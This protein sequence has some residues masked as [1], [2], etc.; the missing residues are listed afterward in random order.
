MWLRRLHL[1]DRDGAYIVTSVRTTLLPQEDTDA[2]KRERRSGI[3]RGLSMGLVALLVAVMS[4]AIGCQKSEDASDYIPL[5]ASP[6]DETQRR[7][8]EELIRMQQKAVPAVTQALKSETPLIR[9]GALKVLAKVRRMDSVQLSGQMIDDPN[10]DVQ[11]Q[12]IISLNEL[13]QVW[14]EKSVELLAHALDAKDAVTVRTAAA[15]LA[16]MTYDPATA[17]LRK[18]FE[19]KQGIKAVYAAQQLYQMEPGDDTAQLLLEDIASPDK[20]VRD[21]EKEALVDVRDA[22]GAITVVGLEDK[23][24]GAL[25][26]YIDAHKDASAAQSMLNQ[27]R[28]ALI[29][30]LGKTL[31]TK[32]AA[33][34]LEALGTIADKE[35]VEKLREDVNDTRLESS[36][37]VSAASSLGIAG[38]SSRVQPAVRIT[39]ITE[40]SSVLDNADDNRVRIGASIALCR[41]RLQ[42][43]VKYLLDQLSG[44]EE[45]ISASNMTESRRQDLT[46][47][48]IRAQEALTQAG[49]YVVPFLMDKIKLEAKLRGMTPEMQKALL[50]LHGEAR[51][52]NIIIWAAAKTMGELKVQEAVPY[53]GGYVTEQ[54][55]NPE[56]TID[57][58]GGLLGAT[59]ANPQGLAPV[60]LALSN[61][62]KPP[63]AEVAADQER[64]EVFAYPDYVRLTA[65]N[66]L[67]GIGGEE[68]R[69]F[70]QK[71]EQEETAFLSRLEA[72]KKAS[73]YYKRAP[74][75]EGLIHKHEDV[76][77]YVRLAQKP[78]GGK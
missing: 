60:D 65:A 49:D 53:L 24:V 4:V 2:M 5:L 47:L 14:K 46:A 39:I 78:A 44:F 20:A 7:A 22:A 11:H 26:R 57:A 73:D 77:F 42:N 34:I 15:A 38:M 32:R 18:A 59:E 1:T 9:V 76:L 58:Q 66:A 54:M 13:A 8:I 64:L 67:G 28:D 23:F 72:C 10:A 41:L 70:L 63:E 35:S 56:I 71:A 12:A 43:G 74:V 50:D 69:Q 36:W 62:Q 6:K 25:V 48:R 61:P 30:E 51:P 45:A 40:L 52:G 3:A 33:T 17:V 27:V 31:D 37:R 16:G 29:D 21:A 68:G 55:K 75:I 19:T